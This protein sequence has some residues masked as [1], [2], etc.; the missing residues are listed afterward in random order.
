MGKIKLSPIQQRENR[1]RFKA[2]NKELNIHKGYPLSSTC[3]KILFSVIEHPYIVVSCRWS[4]NRLL[5]QAT[6]KQTARAR[7]STVKPEGELI[8]IGV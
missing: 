7:S 1:R 4:Y 3:H 2:S 5:K 6:K 8:Q